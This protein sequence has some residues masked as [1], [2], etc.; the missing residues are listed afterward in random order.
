MSTKYRG[1][2][3]SKK[4]ARY[5]FWTD[6]LA[7]RKTAF[8]DHIVVLASEF[9]G[10]V[11][12]LVGLGINPKN[13]T[14]V[15]RDRQA[16][17]AFKRNHPG[18]RTIRADVGPA[19]EYLQK[20][21]VVYLDFCGCLSAPVI[22]TTRRVIKA[23]PVGGTLGITLLKGRERDGKKAIK[24]PTE[25]GIEE[26]QQQMDMLRKGNVRKFLTAIKQDPRWTDELAVR[27]R[28]IALLVSV[29]GVGHKMALPAFVVCYQSGGKKTKGSPMM[30]VKLNIVKA[31]DTHNRNYKGLLNK[32][33]GGKQGWNPI[34][35][36][37]VSEDVFREIVF[38]R[39]QE[40]GDA[41]LVFNVPRGKI[42][43][44]KAHRTMGTYNGKVEK[45]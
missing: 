18:I 19:V 37:D 20:P 16:L 36:G 9:G 10:D 24:L 12:C 35:I 21:P 25:Q 23:M 15:D 45:S 43:A 2:T 14:A 39:D 5:F 33:M 40:W 22:D 17:A 7:R 29:G 30:V 31:M 8:E 44:W 42:S 26:V 6:V 27:E 4:M 41:H 13:I 3:Y 1:E 38:A 28:L 11:P 32:M 34:N